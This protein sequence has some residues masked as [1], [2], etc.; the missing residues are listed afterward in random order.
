MSLTE[1]GKMLLRRWYVTVPGLMIALAVG[2]IVF[3]LVPPQYTSNGVGVLVQPKRATTSSGTANNPLLGFDESL[4]TTAQLLAQSLS[5]PQTSV[6]LGLPATQKDVTISNVGTAPSDGG[7]GQPFLYVTA[8]SGDPDQ[9]V[10]YVST[11]LSMAQQQ[12][13]DQQRD[14][15]VSRLQAITLEDVVA[16]TT[17]KPVFTMSY[18]AA[19]A[20]AVLALI[21]VVVAAGLLDRASA[22]RARARR[23][24]E[25]RKAMA[26]GPVAVSPPIPLQDPNTLKNGASGGHT[27]N[28]KSTSIIAQ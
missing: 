24:A 4:G 15:H 26:A 28:H 22:R 21:V 9:S 12:L 1:I 16:P 19:G 14:M 5:S 6:A 3:A 11:V 25:A 2:G 23:R 13:A 20:A 17:A 18:A 10:G 8:K 27:N 7:V